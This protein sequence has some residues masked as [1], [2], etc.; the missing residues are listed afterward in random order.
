MRKVYQLFLCLII[1]LCFA[2][3][4][5]LNN[6]IANIVY[7][8]FNSSASL[9]LDIDTAQTNNI[10][11]GTKEKNLIKGT[12]TNND[13]M[14]FFSF[15][16]ARSI[17]KINFNMKTDTDSKLQVF[18]ANE[19]DPFKENNSV[20]IDISPNQEQYSISFL[21]NIIP[22]NIKKLRIDPTSNDGSNFILSD[23]IIQ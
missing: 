20:I 21:M 16:E 15:N 12:S 13:P 2:Y 3:T 5:G 10:S 8:Y 1:V 14:M 18:Y 23:I 7:A 19:E 9:K 11:V 4:S 6:I 17:S 22:K